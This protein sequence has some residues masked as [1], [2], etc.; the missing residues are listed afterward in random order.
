MEVKS[1]YIKDFK[2]LKDFKIVFEE[3]K[4][5]NVIIGINAAGK[6]N[7]LEALVIIVR[8]LELKNQPEFG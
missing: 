7:V 2:N 8:D 1:L 3:P 4:L 6:S 5:R